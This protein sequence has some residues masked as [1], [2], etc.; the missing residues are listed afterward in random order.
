[1]RR[2]EGTIVSKRMA[3]T[4]VVRV[5]RLRRHPKY[6]KS[7][8]ISRKYK[9]HVD[10]AAPYGVGDRVRITETRPLSKEKRWKVVE[11]VRRAA[12]VPEA[13]T[14]QSVEVPINDQ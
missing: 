6:R 3:K 11:V 7:F 4:V 9:A 10:D 2:L 13:G 8:R 5:D 14:N 1:M 12:T